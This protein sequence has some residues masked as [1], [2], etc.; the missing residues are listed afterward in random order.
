MSR[1]LKQEKKE[2]SK[3]NFSHNLK[4]PYLSSNLR[5]E[6]PHSM[7]HCQWGKNFIKLFSWVVMMYQTIT[8]G[9]LLFYYMH[10]LLHY[11]EQKFTQTTCVVL[12]FWTITSQMSLCNCM[13]NPLCYVKQRLHFITFH[14]IPT[15]VFFRYM[16]CLKQVG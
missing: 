8:S 6:K 1:P 2:F 5:D 10:D 13:C 7:H 9:M 16:R 3:I 14:N 15:E 12:M 11:L 4:F